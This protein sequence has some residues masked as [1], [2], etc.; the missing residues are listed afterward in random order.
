MDS[1]TPTPGLRTSEFWITVI[2]NVILLA[3][4]AAAMFSDSPWVAT[5][6]ATLPVILTIA[7]TLARLV[8]KS[9]LAKQFDGSPWWEAMEQAIAGIGEILKALEAA[10][11]GQPPQEPPA[12][13]DP[14]PAAKPPADGPP[15]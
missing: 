13:T 9:A 6:F 10:R 14:P 1:N 3:I 5:I 2:V 12:A 15:A 7:Y 4:A 11:N 8:L